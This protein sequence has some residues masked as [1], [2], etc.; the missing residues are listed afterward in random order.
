ML[1]LSTTTDIVQV[2]SSSTAD[3]EVS[4]DFIDFD[5]TNGVPGRQHTKITTATTT[6]VVAAPAAGFYRNIKTLTVRNK[7][8]STSN[9]ATV[10]KDLN[11]TN[12]EYVSWALAAGESLQFGDEGWQ[13]FDSLGNLK[14]AYSDPRLLTQILSSTVT[15]ATTTAAEITGMAKALS[16]GIWVFE[17]FI[18]YR[19]DTTT[20]GIKFS[21]DFSGTT[22]SIVY[23]G[24]IVSATSTASDA[25]A[26][27]DVL[28][29][30]MGLLN[31]DAARAGSSA[32]TM[33]TAGVDTI[34]VDCLFIIR[35]KV[36]VSVAGNIRLWHASEVA[37]TTSVMLN[38]ALRLTR[39]S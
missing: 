21:V 20:T 1:I 13:C 11:G 15:N 35:G 10:R 22:T 6:T 26:D 37:T 12:Y 36:D 9:T 5:G 16:I 38:S 2:V 19:S 32:A 33:V 7:H 29:A 18:R 28:T 17:Y 23:W 31:A 24:E 25:L 39:V 4:A 14:T 8:A 34:N 27:Q 3:L 30:T